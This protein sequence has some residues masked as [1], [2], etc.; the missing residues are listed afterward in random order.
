MKESDMDIELAITTA[1]QYENRV[2]K[3]Y[4]EA[5]A[6]TLDPDGKKMFEVLVRDEQSHV[7]YLEFKLAEWKQSGRVTAGRLDTLV[8]SAA[9]IEA[10]IKTLKSR[11]ATKSPENELRLLRR[12][13][14]VE[15][16]TSGFY[17]SVVGEL[18]A[19]A[20]PLFQRFIEIEEG[21]QK[22]VQAEIDSV[23]GLGFWFDMQEFDLAAG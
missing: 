22:I 15:V 21:H 16:E 14:Q 18:P 7:K 11:V 1:I 13:L 20:R 19:E 10:G 8:P 5:A 17:R 12:A 23:S 3:V 6:A 2:V 4:E 9:R